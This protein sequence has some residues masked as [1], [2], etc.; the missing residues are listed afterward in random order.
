MDGLTDLSPHVVHELQ[1]LALGPQLK[2]GENNTTGTEA[3]TRFGAL[4]GS[5]VGPFVIDRTPRILV[6]RDA[7]GHEVRIAFGSDPDVDIRRVAGGADIPLLAIEVKGGGDSSNKHNRLG[8][9][10]KSHL[11]A[12][13]KGHNQFWTV[14]KLPYTPDQMRS[15]S[16]TTQKLF[17]LDQI[18]DGNSPQG[19]EFRAHL[20]SILGLP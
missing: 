11:K 15:Q 2:G 17:S 8:E 5:I 3:M 18:V 4:I 1:L 19:A 14:A 6:L 9:A 13:G 12:K 16:P 20:G 10:E 7:A